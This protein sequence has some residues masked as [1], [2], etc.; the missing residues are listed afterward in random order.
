M[1]FILASAYL[2]LAKWGWEPLYRVGSWKMLVNVEGFFITIAVLSI[3][4]GLRPYMAS[5]SLQISSKGIKYRGPYWPQR[6]TLNWDQIVQVYLSSELIVVLYHAKPGTKRI[7]PMFI[8]SIYLADRDRIPKA[9]LRHCPIEPVVMTSPHI[10]SRILL[11]LMFL[12]VIIWIL[13]ML[14]APN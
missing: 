8:T 14:V 5:S 6:R 4:V 9:V 13:E 11:G 7:W 10:V 12:G 1:C 3:L 2:G